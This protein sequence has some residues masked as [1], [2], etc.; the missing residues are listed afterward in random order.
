MRF[1]IQMRL[2]VLF[3]SMMLSF[4]YLFSFPSHLL[5]SLKYTYLWL[6]RT[7]SI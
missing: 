2:H 1:R 6:R 5:C 7:V 3:V 4:G